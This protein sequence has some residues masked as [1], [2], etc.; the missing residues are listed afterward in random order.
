MTKL[1]LAFAKCQ[2]RVAWGSSGDLRKVKKLAKKLYKSSM[3]NTVRKTFSQVFVNF[4][5]FFPWKLA[6]CY[7]TLGLTFKK[8]KKFTEAENHYFK[9]LKIREKLLQKDHPDVIA[10]KNNIGIFERNMNIFLKKLNWF[11][12]AVRCH[13]K[14]WESSGISLWRF[15]DY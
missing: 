15:G 12:G 11:R 4:I 2:W 10:I 8:A 13:G 9:S 3:R 1:R 6:N 5:Q 14:L 7:N